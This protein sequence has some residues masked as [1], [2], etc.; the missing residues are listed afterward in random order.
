MLVVVALAAAGIAAYVLASRRR[1]ARRRPRA[2][3]AEQVAETLGGHLD[4]L[5]SEPDPRRAVIAAYA[6]LERALA[7][8]GL[9]R[10]PAETPEEY[11]ARILDE[12]EVVAARSAS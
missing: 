2:P 3:A 1:R 11:V 10:R 4:D 8:S 6:R 7:A 5:R 9:P 12:L